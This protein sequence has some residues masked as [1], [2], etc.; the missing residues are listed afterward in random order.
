MS[1]NSDILQAL[2]KGRK[3]NSMT[4]LSEWGVFRLAA[5]IEQLRQSHDISTTMKKAANGK[6]FAEYKLEN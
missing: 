6:R 1:Q 2:K 5:R 4:A 3:I